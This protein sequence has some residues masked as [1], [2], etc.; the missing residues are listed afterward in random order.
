MLMKLMNQSDLN[1]DSKIVAKSF[2]LT[3]LSYYSLNYFQ[4]MCEYQEFF[5]LG[6]QLDGPG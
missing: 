2:L 4:K 1:L 6:F 3:V 5:Q